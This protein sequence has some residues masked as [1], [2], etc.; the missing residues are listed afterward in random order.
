MLYQIRAGFLYFEQEILAA[1]P[2]FLFLFLILIAVFIVSENQVRIDLIELVSEGNY[3]NL[4]LLLID[5]TKV[6]LTMLEFINYLANQ[7][8]VLFFEDNVVKEQ[9]FT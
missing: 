3:I 6:F 9:L 7:S 1:F 2:A 4:I 5:I 8:L